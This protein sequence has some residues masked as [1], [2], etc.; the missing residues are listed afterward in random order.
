MPCREELRMQIELK[1]KGSSLSMKPIG[2]LSIYSADEFKKCYAKEGAKFKKI[3]IDLSSVSRLD[4]AG[5]QVLLMTRCD[6]RRGDRVIQFVNPSEEVV[7]L[8]EMYQEKI[9]DW[10][11]HEQR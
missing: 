4:S 1:K 3:E 10:N 5:F 11:Y 7:R 2:E 6:A 9:E 8:Y